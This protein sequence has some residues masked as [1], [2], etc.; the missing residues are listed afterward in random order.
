VVRALRRGDEDKRG[1]RE[2]VNEP[3]RSSG[4]LSVCPSPFQSILGYFSN[5]SLRSGTLQ[6]AYVRHGR[7]G[8][9]HADRLRLVRRMHRI[10]NVVVDGEN[11]QPLG[12][13]N[14]AGCYDSLQ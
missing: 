6:A 7:C 1:A 12:F 4:P 13:L 10:H 9:Y 3:H 11:K 14:A 8:D 5:D 2:E